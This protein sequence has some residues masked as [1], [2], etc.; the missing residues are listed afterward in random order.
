[1]IKKFC[2]VQKERKGKGD[3]EC[4]RERERDRQ[5]QKEKKKK[6][7]QPAQLP[8]PS[9]PM[10]PFLLAHV[11]RTKGGHLIPRPPGPRGYK[12]KDGLKKAEN[13]ILKKRKNPR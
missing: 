8:D 11:P 12:W 2:I 10:G 9:V 1:M 4:E 7:S 13:S 3:R 6:N 5:R